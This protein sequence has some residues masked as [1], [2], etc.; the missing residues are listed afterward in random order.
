MWM[1]YRR[2]D[3]N[4]SGNNGMIPITTRSTLVRVAATH[5]RVR[6]INGSSH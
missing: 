1:D 6:Y 3:T 5:G 4:D 2:D